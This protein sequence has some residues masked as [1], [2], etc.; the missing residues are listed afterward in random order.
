[1]RPDASTP[2]TLAEHA[3][4]AIEEAILRNEFVPGQRL[5]LEDLAAQLDMSPMPVREALRRLQTLGFVQTQAHRGARVREVSADD[6]F[7]LYRARLPLEVTAIRLAAQRFTGED[8]ARARELFNRYLENYSRDEPIPAREAHLQFHFALY[9]AAQSEWLLQAIR[10]LCQY[11][12]RY[13]ATRMRQADSTNTVQSRQWE[14]ERILEAC[15]RRDVA[16][17][18]A[19]LAQHLLLTV[20]LSLPAVADV[21]DEQAAE[22]TRQFVESL[23]ATSIQPADVL[24]AIA[25]PADATSIA[26]AM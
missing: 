26:G 17:A 8:A 7:G 24:L 11:G 10:P 3:V 13:R 9:E 20:Q 15:L 5:L 23:V 2:R 6:L 22:M 18:G 21:T 1:M 19:A 25:K 4:R 12:E 16:G 14:H